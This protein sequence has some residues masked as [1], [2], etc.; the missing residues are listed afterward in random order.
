MMPEG[1]LFNVKVTQKGSPSGVSS[2]C[3]TNILPLMGWPNIL[4][5]FKLNVKEIK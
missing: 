4:P 2:N 3:H 5:S 1:L